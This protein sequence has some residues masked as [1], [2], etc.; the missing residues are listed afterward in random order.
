MRLLTTAVTLI[1]AG[2]LCAPGVNAQ[3]EFNAFLLPEYSSIA[4]GSVAEIT[5][6]VDDTAHQFNAYQITILFDPAVVSFISVEEGPLMIEACDNRWTDLESTDSTVTYVH[7]LLCSDVSLDGP[8]VLSLF[9]FQGEADGATGLLHT[10]N[11]DRTFYDEGLFVWPGHSYSRQVV[12]HNAML[13]V[14]VQGVDDPPSN[15]AR[16]SLRLSPNPVR[17]GASIRIGSLVAGGETTLEIVDIL[18]RTLRSWRIGFLE[19]GDQ[20]MQWEGTDQAGRPLPTG[21]YFCRARSGRQ[22]SVGKFRVIR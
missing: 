20:V 2:G 12:L 4:V 16:V 14:G 3:E 11:P 5:F 18:G 15:D 6:E 21:T 13:T 1:A 17:E 19:P 22:T 8:G 9:R 10:T 7:G